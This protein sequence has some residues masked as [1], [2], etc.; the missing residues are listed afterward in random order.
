MFQEL[1][2]PLSSYVFVFQ[3]QFQAGHLEVLLEGPADLVAAL[4]EL[5]EDVLEGEHHI[6]LA[7]AIA[8]VEALLLLGV[9]Q[10]GV[11][12]QGTECFF[13]CFER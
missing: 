2:V 8:E 3:F 6:D 12:K 13:P 11:L 1:V 10:T 4:G 7:Y 5:V 9:F